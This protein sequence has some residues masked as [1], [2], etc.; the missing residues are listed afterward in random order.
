MIS[1]GRERQANGRLKIRINFNERPCV[2]FATATQI[3]AEAPPHYRKIV[4]SKYQ[5]LMGRLLQ[6]QSLI[7][8]TEA[9]AFSSLLLARNIGAF[10]VSVIVF[11]QRKNDCTGDRQYDD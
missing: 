9:R 7:E 10:C 3:S 2:S 1:R 6:R 5:I 8:K 4:K 11:N